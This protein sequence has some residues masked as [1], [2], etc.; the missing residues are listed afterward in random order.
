MKK[1]LDYNIILQWE[2]W[3]N[4]YFYILEGSCCWYE[5]IGLYITCHFYNKK[6]ASIFSSPIPSQLLMPTT[7]QIPNFSTQMKIP[8]KN[9]ES[10]R[11]P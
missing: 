4:Y 6:I 9:L 5:H 10:E 8:P 2:I 3:C 11:A 7:R 1:N